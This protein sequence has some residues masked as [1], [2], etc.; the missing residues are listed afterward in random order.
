MKTR[1][2][3][4]ARTRKAHETR[5]LLAL[6][7]VALDSAAEGVCIYDRDNRVVLHNRRYLEIF[8][9]SPKVVR[10]GTSYRRVL[11][12]SAEMG[13]F[14]PEIVEEKWQDRLRRLATRKPFSMEQ[15]L[16]S[17]TIMTFSFRPLPN[18]AWLAL[19]DDITSQAKLETE[20]QLQTERIDTR[21]PI[22]RMGCACSAP[23]S[24]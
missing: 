6:N 5:A 15:R 7:Q 13:N 16:P 22:C 9:M 11:E 23:M 8:K 3:R 21:S 17:G 20:L 10:R 24:A 1:R 12:H 2:N 14:S 19:Y 18:G 4:R